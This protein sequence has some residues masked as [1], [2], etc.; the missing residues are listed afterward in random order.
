MD[1]ISD[2][3]KSL[4][5]KPAVELQ[6]P[7]KSD[8]R[9]LEEEINGVEVSNSAGVFV[10]KEQLY[11]FDYQ[12]GKVRFERQIAI[13]TLHR[14]ARIKYDLDALDRMLFIDT[15]TSGLAGGA[16]TF[17]FL[18]GV[19]V[20]QN[21][22][23]FLQQ[24][25]IRDPSEE[26]A[27]LLYL[28]DLI[29]PETIFVSFNG[30][31]FDI[32][33]IQN[34]FIINHLQLRLRELS[35]LDIL[36]VSRKLWRRTLASCALKDLETAILEFSRSDDDV[37]GWMIP[38]IY[39]EYLRT[40][41]PAKLADVIY[42]NAQDIVSLAALM[43]RISQLLDV[44][45]YEDEITTND[46]IEISRMYYE[47]GSQD[48]AVKILLRSR[49]RK[50]NP[51]Q[52]RAINLMLGQY[53]KQKENL[54]QAVHHWEVAANNGDPFSTIEL[55]KYYE[56]N[57]HD[58][59]TALSWCQKCSIMLKSDSYRSISKTFRRELDKRILRL[60][61]KGKAYVQETDER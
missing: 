3:L 19:G 17:A 21:D 54:E 34:R 7:Q 30:K 56:H 35:H 12:H 49:A 24:L 16:G 20:F 13:E 51:V 5:F 60:Q 52:E 55:A 43:I 59:L 42:H 57:Q 2:R 1:S 11:P 18:I 37:P 15:E 14:S 50:L 61:V 27:M 25:I 38:D 8:F 32:P 39:F 40:G 33:L 48:L 53:F 26:L 41:D 47:M 28:S 6:K 58:V 46:L 45:Q 9:A 22:G 4:G 44:D 23:F 31:S 29:T 10:K 36:Q